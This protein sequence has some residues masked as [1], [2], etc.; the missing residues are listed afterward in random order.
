MQDPKELAQTHAQEL[1]ASL[2]G[3]EWEDLN[4]DQP[5]NFRREKV[6]EL[7]RLGE[8][9]V[10]PLIDLLGHPDWAIRSDAAIILGYMGNPLA[11]QPLLAIMEND[12]S[13]SVKL[14]SASVLER[15]NVPEFEEITTTWYRKNQISAQQRVSVKMDEFLTYGETDAVL[16]DRARQL[17]DRKN[18]T[19]RTIFDSL[20][21][22]LSSLSLSAKDEV[23]KRNGWVDLSSEEVA[24]L[25][26]PYE[27]H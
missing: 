5:M 15:I 4:D 20:M 19:V 24:Y 8:Y 23:R 27:V 2:C 12:E 1:V 17:A 16:L 13:L 6:Q 7:V 14:S 25:E 22:L 11:I 21:L 3:R 9:A 18:V 10:D 26:E